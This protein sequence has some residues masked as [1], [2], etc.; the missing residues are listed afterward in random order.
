MKLTLFDQFKIA[1]VLKKTSNSK[2]FC[3]DGLCLTW[4]EKAEPGRDCTPDTRCEHAELNGNCDACNTVDGRFMEE[5]NNYASTCDAC[6]EL[7]MHEEL[8]MN[9]ENQ[10]GT[11]QECIK[12]GLKA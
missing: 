6:G 8:T 3:N 7:T 12:K 10:L 5:V 1:E 2:S 11:C 4:F 9:E